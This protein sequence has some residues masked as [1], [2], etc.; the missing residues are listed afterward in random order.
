MRAVSSDVDSCAQHRDESAAEQC[1]D[2]VPVV[3]CGRAAGW[4]RRLQRSLLA[5][6]LPV[7]LL[8][9]RAWVDTKLVGERAARSVVSVKRFGLASC[10]VESEHQLATWPFPQWVLAH[11]RLELGNKLPS[12]AQR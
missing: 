8:Q 1:L 4:S 10:P 12:G 2:D 3:I 6:D 9:L 7:E 5:Q 11:E